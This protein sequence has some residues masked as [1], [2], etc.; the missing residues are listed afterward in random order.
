MGADINFIVDILQYL[1]DMGPDTSMIDIGCG[2]GFAL[3]YAKTMLKAKVKGFEPGLYGD[4][5][6][7]IS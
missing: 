5:G 7:K 6:S 1:P 2:Y 4:I 3:L